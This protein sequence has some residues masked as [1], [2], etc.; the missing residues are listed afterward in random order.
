MHKART[1][2]AFLFALLLSNALHAQNDDSAAA[3]VAAAGWLAIMD[4]GDYPASWD[5][6][7][8]IF[9]SALTS[10]A[11][12]QAATQVRTRLGAM[13]SRADKSLTMA[14]SL[15]GVPDGNYAVLQFDTAYANKAVSVETVSLVLEDGQ[16]KVVGYFIK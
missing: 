6:A 9:K 1:V 2:I 4:A 11:W 15:P 10:A 8:G 14:T 7:A 12:S 3:K 5:A 13:Q 16:W